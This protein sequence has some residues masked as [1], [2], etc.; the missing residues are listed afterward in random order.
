MEIIVILCCLSIKSPEI[1]F[2]SNKLQDLC[3]RRIKKNRMSHQIMPMGLRNFV[4][5]PE[6][7]KMFNLSTDK[8]L[9]LLKTL[10]DFKLHDDDDQEIPMKALIFVQ[11][12]QMAAV[13]GNYLEFLF[14]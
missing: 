10:A 5:A 4:T 8:V 6:R 11:E 1:T 13:L 2:S 7:Q 9:T 3:I 12:R 14:S